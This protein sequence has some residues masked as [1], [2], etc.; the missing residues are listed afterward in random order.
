MENRKA[1]LFAALCSLLIVASFIDSSES[2]SC[3]MK[4]FKRKLPCKAVKGYNIQTIN[5]SC[6]INAIIFH[7][8]GRFVCADPLKVWTKRAMKCVDERRRKVERI[9]RERD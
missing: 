7:L 1:C 6:D 4:Y 3:C 9:L 2:A 5:G 8:N